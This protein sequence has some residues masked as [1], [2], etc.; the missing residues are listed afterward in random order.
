VPRAR[1]EYRATLDRLYRRRRF[2]FRPGLEVIRAVL[3]ALGEPQRSFPAVHVT[4]S[5]GKGSVSAMTAE[6]LSAHGLRV[7]LFTS[8]HLTRYAERIREGDRP[9]PAA[10]VTRGVTR[11]EEAVAALLKAGGIDREP[12]FFEITT[13]L[14]LDWFARRKVDAAVIEVGIGGRLDATNVLDA[15]VG[16]ITTIE[17]E[18]TDVLG[19]TLA[20]IA[21]E[22]SGILHPGMRGVIGGLPEEADAVVARTA[23]RLGVSLWRLGREVVVD[24]RELQPD[25]QSFSVR[26]PGLAVPRVRIPLLGGFQVGNAGLAVAAAV[27]FLD[28]TGRSARP[29]GVTRGLAHVRWP[30]RLERA[31][32]QPELFF[33]V[34]H[35]PESARA[36]T[37]SLGEIAPLADPAASA[38]VF[39]CLRGKQTDRILD[40]L[41]PLARTVVLVPVR[42]AR[43]LPPSEIRVAAAGRFPR[44]VEAPN[45]ADGLR[46]ARAATGDE[47]FTLVTG[48]D[49]LVGELREPRG[50]RDEP[51]LSDPGHEPQ[52]ARG[53]GTA[54]ARTP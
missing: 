26:V 53:P 13:A 29:G 50:R 25:G 37:E 27:R 46:L 31:G 28:A 49:Y 2:G 45:A 51:D 11:I 20:A 36:V 30:G 54:G 17:L 40:A 9:I 43:G 15:R 22:K 38:I 33:D 24:D 18:H 10:A 5:K 1:A 39:G 23:D 47:G 6:I 44:V 42:S 14:A 35:T 8:P 32:R 7:G 41:S 48:S 3:S 16:V 34:A 4:G 52:P 21:E 19:T 12:T